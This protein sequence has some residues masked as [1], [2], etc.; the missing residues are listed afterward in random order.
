MNFDISLTP[1]YLNG[2]N[3][4]DDSTLRKG[5]ESIFEAREINKIENNLNIRYRENIAAKKIINFIKERVK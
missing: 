4:I 2:K 3:I 1:Q 5:I